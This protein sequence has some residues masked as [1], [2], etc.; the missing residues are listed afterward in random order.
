MPVRRVERAGGADAWFEAEAP[1]PL[2]RVFYGKQP[3]AEA[4]RA[5]VKLTGDKALAERFVALFA[6]PRKIA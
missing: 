4:R 6:L 5:G 2:L 1:L 3:L